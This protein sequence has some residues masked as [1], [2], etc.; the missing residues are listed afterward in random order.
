MA[1]LE[2]QNRAMEINTEIQTL[3]AGIQARGVDLFTNGGGTLMQNTIDRLSAELTE[4]QNQLNQ[5]EEDE[6]EEA[7]PKGKK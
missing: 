4:I 2:L 1:R 5:P 3:H 7:K 6:A